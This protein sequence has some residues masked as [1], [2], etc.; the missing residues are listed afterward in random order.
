MLNRPVTNY[1]ARRDQHDWIWPGSAHNGPKAMLINGLAGSGGDMFPW[2]FRH[3]NLGPL[4]GTRTWGGLVGISG[5]PGM[6]DGSGVR[7]P[8]FAFYEKDGT[9]GIEGHGVDPTVEVLD[10]PG[11]MK[12]GPHYGGVDPQMDKAVELLLA[13]LARAPVTHPA[14]P[15]YPNR[16]GFG[17]KP[18]DK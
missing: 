11:V 14:R 6:I 8:V 18:E 7:V 13:E 3:E 2:L 4:V 9:W 10:D 1:W 15:A 12:G 5:N 17:I 16:S